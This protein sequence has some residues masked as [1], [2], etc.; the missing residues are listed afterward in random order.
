MI[1][2]LNI[3]VWTLGV[4]FIV[5]TGWAGFSWIAFNKKS[6]SYTALMKRMRLYE[7]SSI[8]VLL[9]SSTMMIVWAVY[10][11]LYI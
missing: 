5:S 1:Q 7:L 3:L 9:A 6:L 4:V 10:M 2:I 8:V 11:S